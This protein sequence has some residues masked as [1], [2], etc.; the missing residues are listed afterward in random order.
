MILSFHPVIIGDVQV[1]LGDRTIGAEE[2]DLIRRAKAI[3]LPQSRSR[4][5]HLACRESSALLFPNYEKRYD[6]EGKI[7]QSR[8][9][10]E[11]GWP[12]PLTLRWSSTR[13]FKAE[14]EGGLPHRLP[15]FLKSNR[16]HEGEGVYLIRES[17]DLEFALKEIRRKGDS[18]FISQDLVPSEGNVLRVVLMGKKSYTYWKRPSTPGNL[19][20]TISSG[21]LI[22]ETWRPELQERGAAQAGKIS[23]EGGINLAA[24][25]FVFPLADPVPQPLILEINYYFGRRGLGGSLRYYRLLLDTVREWLEEEGLDPQTVWL[26]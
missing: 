5:L 8:L 20:T 15:F 10:Q 19:I 12:H 16:C 21:S 1:I 23:K 26:A 25:D 13:S 3:I 4:D 14:G 11:M 17:S 22:E 6:Y 24:F 7:G 18:G 9:F 2:L